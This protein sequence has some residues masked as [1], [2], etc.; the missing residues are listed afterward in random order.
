MSIAGRIARATGTLIPAALA[1]PFGAPATVF[2]HGVEPELSDPEIQINQHRKDD[3]A[4][5]LRLIKRDFDVLPLAALTDVLKQPAKHSRALFLMS[6]DGYA[7]ALTVAADMLSEFAL[8]WTL[9]ISTHHIDTGA[10][11][12]M[13]TA[14]GFFLLA[15][16]GDYEIPHFGTLSL[17]SD[18]AVAGR[19]IL[20]RLKSLPAA[21]A[22][23]AI[24]AMQAVLTD[25]GIDIAQ[26]FPSERFLTWD[27]I[28]ALDRRG[29]EIGAHADWHWPMHDEQ[30]ADHLREQAVRPKLRIEKEIGPCRA[31]AYPFGQ[32]ADVSPS[33]WRAVRDAGYDAA[34]TTIAGTLDVC[35]NRWLLPRYG[36]EPRESNLAAQIPLMRANNA[37]LRQWQSRIGT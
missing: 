28:R 2:F 12:P 14:R 8:P 27:Q 5:I 10:L 24:A 30:T 34:F 11:N 7:N 18:R 22:G 20:P 23:E 21:P 16:N 1:R 29:V 3:F 9:F 31:F 26:R 25:A 4:A 32:R 17:S 35:E 13:T 33:A 19:Q 6:D 36:L 37:R 15:P